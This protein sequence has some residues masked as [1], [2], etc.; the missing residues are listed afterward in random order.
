MQLT[1]LTGSKFV[2]KS[3]STQSKEVSTI[4]YQWSIWL[5]YT[6]MNSIEQ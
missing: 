6:W 3:I 4:V 1:V 2:K 5:D